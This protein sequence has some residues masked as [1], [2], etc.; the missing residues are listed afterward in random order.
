MKYYTFIYEISFFYFIP[1]GFSK[2][3]H[4]CVGI[5]SSLTSGI[6]SHLQTGT[7]R[8]SIRLITATILGCFR[9]LLENLVK[10][11]NKWKHFT[12]PYRINIFSYCN[13]IWKL[14]EQMTCSNVCP[15][16]RF[17]MAV[18]HTIHNA[19]KGSRV[20]R[21]FF[22]NSS[23]FYSTFMNGFFHINLPGSD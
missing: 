12:Q 20:S 13:V 8:N 1:N 22:K 19:D 4:Q 17:F 18:S 3:Y 16:C 11:E 5:W 6:H 23:G 15:P 14:S 10:C 7:P 21:S 2:A 9:I